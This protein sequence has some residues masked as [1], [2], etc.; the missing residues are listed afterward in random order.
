MAQNADSSPL[1]RLPPEIKSM[2]FSYALGQ[3][4]IHIGYS[5]SRAKYKV[6]V[7]GNRNKTGLAILR[8]C[9]QVYAEA[10][11]V[12]WSM[13]KFMFSDSTALGSG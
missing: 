7:E 2:I 8:T 12:F 13:N 1:L 9:R 11:P 10:H 6:R 3:H 4:D 5:T